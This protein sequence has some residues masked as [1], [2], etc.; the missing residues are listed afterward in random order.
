MSNLPE[1]R[2]EKLILWFSE[3]S[4]KDIPLVGGKGA[5]LGELTAIPVPVP[6]GFCVTSKA[7]FDFLQQGSLREKFKTYLNKLDVNNNRALEEASKK[8]QTA[9]LGAKMSEVLVADLHRAYIRLSGN[10]DVDVAVRSSATAED[11]PDASFAGQ[12]ESFLNIKGAAKVVDSV[13]ECWASLFTPRAIFYRVENGYDHFKVG[14]CV[15]VQLM[16]ESEVSGVMFTVDPLTNDRTKIAIEAVFGLGQTIVSGEITPDQYLIDKEKETLINKRV[17]PQ[18][19]QLSH[20]G[21]VEISDSFQKC[22]KLPDKKVIELALIGKT[23]EQHYGAPQ[24]IE[25]AY[26]HNKLWIVQARPV[27]TLNIKNSHSSN[28]E[29]VESL[30]TKENLLLTGLGASPGVAVGKVRMIASASELD[31]VKAGEILVTRMTNPDFVPAMR[32]AVAVVTDEGGRTSHA[33][34]VSR[35]L[36]IVCVVGTEQAT[37]MLK[38]GEIITVDGSRGEVYAGDLKITGRGEQESQNS[39][40]RITTATKL[41]V[42]LAEPEVAEKTALKNVDGVGLLRAEFMMASIGEHPRSIIEKG[43]QAQ[44]IDKLVDGI[45]TFARAFKPRPVIYRSSDFKSN[46]YRFLKGGE[47]YETAEN[48]PLIGFRGAMRY[49]ADPEVFRMELQAL[50]KVRNK[51]HYKNVHLML[52][53]VRTVEELRRVKGLV[54]AEGLNRG[55]SFKLYLMVEI[56]ANVILLEEFAKV[57]IDGISIGSNDLTMLVLGADRDSD[58]LSKVYTEMDEAVLKFLEE[59]IKKARKLG[60]T[61]SICGQA[62]SVYPEL[63]KKLVHWGITSVSVS[64]DVIGKTRR[65]LSEAEAE[66]VRR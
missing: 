45:L 61:S 44:Y 64:P 1:N 37:K 60:L 43:E 42:N 47:K 41:Y 66:L 51:H 35:E 8:I 40:V 14:I 29:A 19:W 55:A 4:R 24:D 33:A 39:E 26:S 52:P 30:E 59:A 54:A 11:L 53:F 65:L 5:N 9:I 6:G 22:Q 20:E 34:I 31:K 12:Q 48:N 49:L 28:K 13:Q 36:G 7:Y 17:I 2:E 23:I 57:G 18:T 15:V 50:L 27:T 21:K 62:P 3:L 38:D 10:H 56:P 63:T 32:R 16:V 58:R 46:E 25:W